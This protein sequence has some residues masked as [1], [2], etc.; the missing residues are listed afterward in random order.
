MGLPTVSTVHLRDQRKARATD[1]H[2]AALRA[3]KW[4]LV[5]KHKYLYLLFLSPAVLMVI[6]FQY[7]PMVG[8]IMAFQRFD[9]SVGSYLGSP[10]IG[11]ENFQT[12]LRNPRFYQALNNTIGLSM[13]TLFVVFPLPIIFALLLNEVRNLTV[14]RVVQTITYLPHF[15]SWVVVATMVYK[16]LD[17][18]H[19]VI[20]QLVVAFGGE[21]SAFMRDPSAFWAITIVSSIWKELGWSAIIYIAAI[22]SIDPQLFEA[23]VIDG[24]NRMRM[25][26]HITLPSIA[27]TIALM[28]ILKVS[29]IVNSQGLFDAVFNLSNPM[30]NERSYTLEMYSYYEGIMS[31][32]YAYATAITLTQAVVGLI[33]VVTANQIYKK[34]TNKSVF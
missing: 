33:L 24:A 6:L 14:K 7:R 3:E 32:K 29:T 11:F 4:A 28:F 10:F 31:G 26:W 13:L 15:I 21:S 2:R 8:V 23:A 12:F 19:G 20:N 16:L 30:V 5:R 27:E 34:L 25:V 1:P 22:A 9:I 17:P 18:T